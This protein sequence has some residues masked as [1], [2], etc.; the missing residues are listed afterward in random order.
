[1]TY[2]PNNPTPP[3][4]PAETT[5]FYMFGGQKLGPVPTQAILAMIQSRALN[6]S[7]MVWREGMSAWTPIGGVPEFAFA[8]SPG[9]PG[10]SREEGIIGLTT[11]GFVLF[12]ILVLFCIPLCWLPW[13]IKGTRVSQP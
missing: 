5:W 3:Q 13:V 2:P 12:I 1:M 9:G 4:F 11:G 6:Q 8:F 7:T 10:G